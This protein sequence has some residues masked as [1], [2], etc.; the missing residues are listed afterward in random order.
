MRKSIVVSGVVLVALCAAAFPAFAQDPVRINVACPTE[1]CG[2]Y[3]V[4]TDQPLV[5]WYVW[6]ATT[7][8]L[9]REFIKKSDQTLTLR[10]GTQE[11]WSMNAEQIRAAF[12]PVYEV[13]AESWGFD[14]PMPWMHEAYYEIEI[15]PLDEGSY[16]LEWTQSFAQPVNDGLH[17][18]TDISGWGDMPTPSLYRGEQG[19]TVN[20]IFVTE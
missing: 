11:V 13:T 20:T 16:T 12:W 9:T 4:T 19:H 15:P 5:L 14:C 6:G 17:A 8:G 1:W 18:C 2:E 10:R 7:K 3:I